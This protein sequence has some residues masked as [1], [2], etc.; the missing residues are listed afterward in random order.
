MASIWKVFAALGAV[1][2]FCG[3]CAAAAPAP[4]PNQAAPIGFEVVYRSDSALA[5]K[6]ASEFVH[7]AKAVADVECNLTPDTAKP[8]RG[9]NRA[10]V[11][12]GGPSRNACSRTLAKDGSLTVAWNSLGDEG[13]V[14]KHFRAKGKDYL[15]LGGNTDLAALYAVYD[16]FE[17]FCKAGYFWDG[18]TISPLPQLPLDRVNNV[19]TPRLAIRQYNNLGHWL[20]QK[21]QSGFWTLAEWQRFLDWMVKRKLNT[22]RFVLAPLGYQPVGR[23]PYDVVRQLG[24]PMDYPAEKKEGL[25][26]WPLDYQTRMTRDVINYGRRNGI[27]FMYTHVVGHLPPGFAQKYPQFKYTAGRLAASDPFFATYE[28]KYLETLIATFG[29]DHIY[30][31][32]G[33]EEASLGDSPA[34]Q[35]RIKTEGIAKSIALAAE[36]DPEALCCYVT[37]DFGCNPSIWT[38][39][40][41]R[42]FL[43]GIP[44]GHFYIYDTNF[45][46]ADP[47]YYERTDCFYGHKWGVGAIH[48]MAGNDNL[49][50]D[51][52]DIINRFRKALN[53]PRS[54]NLIGMSLVPEMVRN[55]TLYFDTMF[56]L[57]WNPKR[58]ANVQDALLDFAQRRYG[59]AHAARLVRPLQQMVDT[60]LVFRVND[61][62]YVNRFDANPVFYKGGHQGHWFKWPFVEGR[63]GELEKR[64][65]HLNS[66][67]AS[68]RRVLEGHLE[69]REAL[70]TNACYVE[71]GVVYAREW[72]GHSFN[73]HIA[74]AWD[75]FKAGDLPALEQE[76]ALAMRCL[77]WT[78]RI[79]S[80]RPD[81]SVEQSIREITAV[82]GAN[83]Y[84]PYFLRQSLTL[85]EYNTVDMFELIPCF[86]APKMEAFFN[87]LKEK[88]KRGEKTVAVPD[89]DRIWHFT[90]L[91]YCE[92]K[93]PIPEDYVFKGP[94]LEA[95]QAALAD[96]TLIQ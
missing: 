21:Y 64:R 75:A 39:E 92:N 14:Q 19:Q 66:V 93:V 82:P 79:L 18:E 58:F 35:I 2:L 57:A 73:C 46:Y 11:L 71:D 95:I 49:H 15:V 25:W 91:N 70:Q 28:K 86:Y 74:R 52:A 87:L 61:F 17:R 94:A 47:P 23:V 76:S 13:F 96:A 60:L 30:D 12:I 7:Y 9:K 40:N 8:I 37:Y 84:A 38:P 63:E 83:K 20:P 59:T 72:L 65:R 80:T 44:K 32:C 55:H 24:Y 31:Y 53:D 29:T 50:G 51:Y 54:T 42:K 5:A 43:T 34:E 16:Y 26:V 27:K 45:E 22:S 56:S 10:A 89:C 90:E 48:S 78:G 69:C 3:P 88:V 4:T 77:S 33:F 62:G 1:P 68:M 36:V 81:Y 67:A 6:A 85:G 41:I